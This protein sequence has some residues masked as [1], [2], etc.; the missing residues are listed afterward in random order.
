MNSK[1]TDSN[2]KKYASHVSSARFHKTEKKL[3]NTVAN[4]SFLAKT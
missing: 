1:Q 3:K 4:L 2:E